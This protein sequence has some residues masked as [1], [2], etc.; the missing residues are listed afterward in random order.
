MACASAIAA[1][2]FL[3]AISGGMTWPADLNAVA[4]S[5]QGSL[6]PHDHVGNSPHECFLSSI[7]AMQAEV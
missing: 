7:I 6:H 5:S 3:A 4:G 2:A 1:A